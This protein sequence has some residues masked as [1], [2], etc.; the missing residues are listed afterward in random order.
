MT[1]HAGRWETISFTW[2]HPEA[3]RLI[4]RLG[5][6]F[7]DKRDLLGAIYHQ[8]EDESFSVF[9]GA[10]EEST[11]APSA[12]HA[13]SSRTPFLSLD[14]DRTRIV[15]VDTQTLQLDLVVRFSP[16]LGGKDLRVRVEADDADGNAQD[17]ELARLTV[18]APS[19]DD[20]PRPIIAAGRPRPAARDR[21]GRTGRAAGMT[22]HAAGTDGRGNPRPGRGSGLERRGR[23]GP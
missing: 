5:I 6:R 19:L 22:G 7:A 15:N 21:D 13:A 20:D 23:S 11:P 18:L 3:W 16:Q 14:L 2:Q 12:R 8:V 9:D 1:S 10:S 17:E 4:D